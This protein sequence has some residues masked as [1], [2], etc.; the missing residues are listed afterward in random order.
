MPAPTMQQIKVNIVAALLSQGYIKREII[1][2]NMVETPTE[3]MPDMDKLVSSIAQG[4]AI[5]WTVWQTT[6]IV[7]GSAAVTTA[8]GV[9]PVIANLP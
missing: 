6:Q 3:L 7:Q 8:P 1:N 5:T 2:G 9:A 4:I